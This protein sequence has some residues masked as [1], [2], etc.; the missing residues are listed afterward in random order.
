MTRAPVFTCVNMAQMAALPAGVTILL[1]FCVGW[2]PADLAAL[3]QL[4]RQH[5]TLEFVVLIQR[6]N[7]GIA[8]SLLPDWPLMEL[9]HR[10]A[11][12]MQVSRQQ[13]TAH[14]LRVLPTN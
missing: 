2:A 12:H 4:C 11:V 9:V 3:G 5:P 7:N 14:Y 13:F 6:G 1:G 8:Q 10:H